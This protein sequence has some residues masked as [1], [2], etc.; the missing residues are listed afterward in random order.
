MD[1]TIPVIV[2][3]IP[4]RWFPY[5]FSL[6][7]GVENDPFLEDWASGPHG[8]K[9][10]I[11]DEFIDLHCDCAGSRWLLWSTIQAAHAGTVPILMGSRSVYTAW[12]NGVA[13]LDQP[14]GLPPGRHPCW[15]LPHY[16]STPR[17]AAVVLREGANPLLLEFVQPEG[18]RVRAY[19]AFDPPPVSKELALRWFQK[20]NDLQFN[21]EP[22]QPATAQWF[23]FTAPPGLIE[24]QAVSRGDVC[25]WVDGSPLE[26]QSTFSRP[27]GCIVSNWRVKQ[28]NLDTAIVAIRLTNTPTG[29]FAG[30]CLPEP[31]T[32]QCTMGRT[33]LVDWKHIGLGTYSGLGIYRQSFQLTED[34]AASGRLLLDLGEVAATASVR[35][36]GTEAGTLLRP[37]WRLDIGAHIRPGENRL[38]ITVANTLAN[39]YSV[40]IPTPY[41][42]SNHQRSGLLGPVRLHR[43]AAPPKLPL[44]SHSSH[45]PLFQPATW[46]R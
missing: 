18:Q 17:E 11:P 39:H 36:N 19:V 27:D 42:L 20:P 25:L 10:S 40:G 23:R 37:P 26:R 24:L 13:V 35:I 46:K 5:E 32:M 12:V 33:R 21:C 8:L 34:Q 1:P 22:R 2:N 28:L 38:Q 6:R 14:T 45:F 44:C 9:P 29:S 16:Q 3:E 41:A 4:Y 31:V 43:K 7:W 15:N 30:D